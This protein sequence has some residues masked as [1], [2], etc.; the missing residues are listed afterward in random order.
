MAFPHIW[1]RCVRRYRTGHG[2]IHLASLFLLWYFHV[3]P[4]R[5]I[6]KQLILK[7]IWCRRHTVSRW[8][9]MIYTST[10]DGDIDLY[11]MDLETG[12]ET[13]D[14]Q[15]HW[16]TMVAPGLAR[17]AAKLIWRASRPKNGCW[18]KGIQRPAG[19]NLVAPT[20]MEVFIANA[21]GQ[22]CQTGNTFW[23]ANWAPSYF[24]D[25][26][27]INHLP[28]TRIKRG[29]PFQSLFHQWRWYPI[30]WRSHMKRSLMPSRCFHR[31]ER[32]SSLQ[33]RNNGE[34]TIPIYLL[35]IGWNNDI[36]DFRF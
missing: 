5:K 8:K 13:A 30:R 9:E 15:Q 31:M 23:Q 18:S 10:K 26:K 27:R 16:A 22:Q 4:W 21:D 25:S 19:R 7:W 1:W 2:K 29:F 11:V 36:S 12:K 20:N 24:P 14:H 6:V 35:L 17:M 3:R 28:A 34:H 33:Q 32:R